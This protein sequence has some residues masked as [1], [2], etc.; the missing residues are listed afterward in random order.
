VNQ[1]DLSAETLGGEPEATSSGAI[2]Q[3]GPYRIVELLGEGGMGQVYLGQRDLPKRT[4]AIKL[5]RG[6]GLS[7]E[8]VTRFRR[9][10]EVLARLEHAG[11]AH[12]YESG[13][14]DDG[15]PWYAMEYVAGRTLD[16]HVQAHKLGARVV[17]ALV[18]DIARA[19]HYAHQR[20]VIHRDIKP[21]NILV[22]AAGQAKI[23]DFGIARLVE[24]DAQGAATRMGQVIGTLAYMSP[25]Q[26]SNSALVHVRT[27]VYA[28]GIVLFEMLTGET[29]VRIQSSSLLEAIRELSEGKRRTLETFDT[30]LRGELSLIVERAMA[31]DPEQR[32]ESAAAFADDLDAYLERK[33]IK[34]RK[35]SAWYVFGK[36]IRRNPLPTAFAAIALLALLSAVVLSSLSARRAAEALAQSEQRSQELASVST[37]LSQM[38]TEADPES[39]SQSGLT[40][41]Q[42]LDGAEQNFAALPDEPAIRAATAM[43]LARARLGSGEADKAMPWA[44]RALALSESLKNPATAREARIQKLVIMNQSGQHQPAL[45]EIEKT[46]PALRTTLGATHPDVLAIRQ[47]QVTAL[48]NLGRNQEALAASSE[49][50]QTA[51]ELFAANARHPFA[52][53]AIYSHGV[54]QRRLGQ[55]Q[56]AEQTQRRALRELERQGFSELA[57]SLHI[58]QALAV[59][60][61]DQSRFDEAIAL[62]DELITARKR[63]LGESHPSTITSEI[64]RL[65]NLIGAKRSAEAAAYAA[66]VLPRAKSVLGEEH[67]TYL[68]NRQNHALLLE[69]LGQLDAAEAAMRELLAIHRRKQSAFAQTMGLRNNLAML[70]GKRGQHEEARELMKT[71]LDD[72]RAQLGEKAAPLGIFLSNAGLLDHQAGR[73]GEARQKL[74]QA[75]EL[76]TASMGAE[77]PRA[78]M[79]K[80]RLAA[81]AH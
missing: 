24:A 61:S 14:L 3:C 7:G 45:D 62:N 80:E 46:L 47:E 12:L 32:Y 49:Y 15:A 37:F 65:T 28:L 64:A 9:E 76:L 57:R 4:A 63:W 69:D 17:V 40:M 81:L 72:T 70:L 71:L 16:Q 52:I 75:I 33:P 11:I 56:E 58:K 73:I 13:E 43:I 18:R 27:D 68:V 5:M 38:L 19:L 8:R 59:V 44:E 42:V 29:P 35:Q 55:Y 67:Q 21:S 25:E 31:R 48:F 6:E 78:V 51:W 2:K 22:D 1:V 50:Q 30:R 39:A 53:A 20:G 77:H 10:V 74:T 36:L 79:A 60:L 66:E 26:L 34:A 41:R 23:L 54:V